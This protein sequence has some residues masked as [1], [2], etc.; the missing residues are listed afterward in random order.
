MQRATKRTPMAPPARI[1][2]ED[3]AS[4]LKKGWSPREI[5]LRYG[6]SVQNIYARMKYQREKA[7][8]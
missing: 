2:W 4:L 7:S 1:A 6:C 5:A 3:I 8:R